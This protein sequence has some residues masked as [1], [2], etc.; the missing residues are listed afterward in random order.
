MAQIDLPFVFTNGAIAVTSDQ[1]EVDR[2]NL[3]SLIGT[4]PGERCMRPTYGVRSRALLFESNDTTILGNQLINDINTAVVTFAPE[5]TIQ[6]IG[7]TPSTGT[8]QQASTLSVQLDYSG[9]GSVAT[10]TLNF[11]Q[12]A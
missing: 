10:T 7:I 4:E 12:G 9:P 3:V 8:S 5:L 2:I 1:A 6:D 11:V